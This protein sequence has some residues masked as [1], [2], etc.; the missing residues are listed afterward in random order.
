MKIRLED[1]NIESVYKTTD[2]NCNDD[3]GISATNEAYLALHP[4]ADRE[5]YS[6][7]NWNSGNIEIVEE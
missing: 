2:N 6:L 5:Y 7:S 1:G 3:L 4:E